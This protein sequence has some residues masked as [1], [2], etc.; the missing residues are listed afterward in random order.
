MQK[1]IRTPDAHSILA[2]IV[3]RG[4]VYSELFDMDTWKCRNKALEA[5]I[6]WCD[7]KEKAIRRKEHE[8]LSKRIATN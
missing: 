7:D 6:V 3:H 8:E 2:E 1:N 5:A 4:K